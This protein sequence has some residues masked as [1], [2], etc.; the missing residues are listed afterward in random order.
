MAE[1]LRLL[2]MMDHY[3]RRC[4]AVS[5]SLN[6]RSTN[7][8]PP[9]P[10]LILVTGAHECIRSDDEPELTTKPIRKWLGGVGIRAFCIDPRLNLLE[11]AYMERDGA[12]LRD[13]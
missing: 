3:L 11:D 12:K 2:R 4:L 6:F 7:V 13:E 9:L 10:K 5:L 1:D 8:I